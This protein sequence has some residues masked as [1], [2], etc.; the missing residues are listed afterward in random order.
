MLQ[1]KRKERDF[2][3]WGEGNEGSVFIY[4]KESEK[5]G[6]GAERERERA[7]ERQDVIPFSL[8]GPHFLM[9]WPRPTPG[10]KKMFSTRSLGMPRI[11]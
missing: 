10:C 9:R 2:R 1:R 3:G 6:S 5:A 8:G 7:R 4:L 11:I